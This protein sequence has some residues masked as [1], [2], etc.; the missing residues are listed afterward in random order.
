MYVCVFVGCVGGGFPDPPDGPHRRI[1]D[2]KKA[3]RCPMIR[4][5]RKEV[6]LFV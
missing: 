3:G 6:S 5:H 1:I 4:T 2:K